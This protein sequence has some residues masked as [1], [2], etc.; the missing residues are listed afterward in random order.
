MFSVFFIRQHGPC[1]LQIYKR[2]SKPKDQ[3]NKVQQLG[4]SAVAGYIAGI[5]CAVVSSGYSELPIS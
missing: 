5:F 1:C 2:L 3:Y 4:V